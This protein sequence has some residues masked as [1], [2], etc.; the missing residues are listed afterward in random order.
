MTGRQTPQTDTDD[1]HSKQTDRQTKI[2]MH[3]HD[4][5]DKQA[6]THT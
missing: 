4:K 3:K 1:T 5:H 6:Y 2:H